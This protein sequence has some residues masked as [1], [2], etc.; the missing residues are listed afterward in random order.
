[1]TERLAVQVKLI[2][3]QLNLNHNHVL[4]TYFAPDVEG[5]PQEEQ[6]MINPHDK[7]CGHKQ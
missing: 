1:M 2:M 3:M 5:S 4:V 6:E 7:H